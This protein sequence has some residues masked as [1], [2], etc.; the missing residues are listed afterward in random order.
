MC[1]FALLY[2][3]KSMALKNLTQTVLLL[4]A[5][6]FWHVIPAKGEL[7]IDQVGRQIT[8][9]DNPQRIVS[10]MPSITETI[11]ALGAGERVKGVT[12]F[13]N[14]PLE[15]AQLP[16][17]GSY[18]HLD[19]E[20]I[21]SL[22]PDL[23][24]AARDGNP[25]HIVDKLTDLGIAVFT[26][27]PRNMTEIMES[28]MMLGKILQSEERAA[29]IVKDM[30]KK[31]DSVAQRVAPLKTKPRVFFQ[32]DASPIISA[33]SKT[34]IDQLIHQAGGINMAS[35]SAAYPRY[36]WEDIL[37]MQPEIV[38]IASMAGGYSDDDL[39]E[40][41]LKWA[42]IPAVRNNRIHVVDA[43][44][45]DRPTA[46]LADGLEMLADIFYPSENQ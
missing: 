12:L 18:V 20:K 33:G 21:V 23:C 42:Q 1:L 35:G 19:L 37:V 38:I 44:L 36:S 11:F 5:I 15:A 39:K 34:F 43:S 28:I 4:C 46:R 10:L 40:K 7:V 6:L 8:I 22:R 3:I 26:I 14:E 17:I 41:W 31:I 9:P 32:I 2:R 16:K 45:F 30:Q 29:S 13:S 25:K 27:D 24:L